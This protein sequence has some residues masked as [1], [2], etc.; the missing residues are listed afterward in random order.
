MSRFESNT[1]V[2]DKHRNGRTF[3]Q[4]IVLFNLLSTQLHCGIDLACSLKRN[5]PEATALT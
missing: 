2:F 3:T 4:L 5:Y 1:L